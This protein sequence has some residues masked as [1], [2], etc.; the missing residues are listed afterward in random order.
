MRVRLKTNAEERLAGEAEQKNLISNIAHDLKTPITA[1]KGTVDGQITFKDPF[2][3]VIK[4]DA[5]AEEKHEGT[6]EEAKA[7]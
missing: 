5:A 3:E 7:E 2:V 4:T 6:A 1:I